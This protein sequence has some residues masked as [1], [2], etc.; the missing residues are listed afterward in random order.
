MVPWEHG[1]FALRHV[2]GKL[3]VADKAWQ[4]R[5][6]KNEAAKALRKGRGKATAG[7]VVAKEQQA[8]A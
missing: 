7:V 4:G 2:L 6:G 5:V 1:S 8:Q 3:T